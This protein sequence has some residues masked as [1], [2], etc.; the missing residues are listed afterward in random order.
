MVAWASNSICSRSQFRCMKTQS[1]PMISLSSSWVRI[2]SP[3]ALRVCVFLTRCELHNMMQ[4]PL[5]Y[6]TVRSIIRVF[7]NSCLILLADNHHSGTV[8][9][10]QYVRSGTYISR[11][12]K[13]VPYINAGK[14]FIFITSINAYILILLILKGKIS[15]D[16]TVLLLTSSD[17]LYNSTFDTLIVVFTALLIT[18]LELL[19]ITRTLLH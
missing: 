11:V 12:N 19:E 14:R 5:T 1:W 13:S 15:L 16:N 18:A 8:G 7:T 9:P 4:P 17:Q 3:L 6:E 2:T 10:T